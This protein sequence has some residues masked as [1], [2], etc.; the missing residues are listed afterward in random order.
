MAQSKPANRVLEIIQV[1]LT[2]RA[3]RPGRDN[4]VSRVYV[5]VMRI[6]M[7]RLFTSVIRDV[8]RVHSLV[9]QQECTGL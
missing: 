3:S 6:I 8:N 2:D 9:L 4:D 5:S 7:N 1:D